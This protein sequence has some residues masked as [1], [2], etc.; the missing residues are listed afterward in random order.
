MV[1][2]HKIVWLPKCDTQKCFHFQDVANKRCHV[3][4][5]LWLS[6]FH[7]IQNCIE[8]DGSRIE[9]DGGTLTRRAAGRLESAA[10]AGRPEARGQALTQVRLFSAGQVTISP[11][12]F[13][14]YA[15][16]QSV[17]PDEVPRR[18]YLSDSRIPV[19]V[20]LCLF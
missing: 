11:A 8:S 13:E 18:R 17:K 7:R 4:R 20:D 5:Q 15:L 14:R 3:W 10:N 12:R 2:K 1:G 9:E 16:P 19:A 6:S